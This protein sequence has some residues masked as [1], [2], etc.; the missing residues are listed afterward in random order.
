MIHL[1]QCEFF[2]FLNKLSFSMI[3]ISASLWFYLFGPWKVPVSAPV[4]TFITQLCTKYFPPPL[5]CLLV[6]HYERYWN[7]LWSSSHSIWSELLPCTGWTAGQLASSCQLL[8][9]LVVLPQISAGCIASD[10]PG[11]LR[12]IFRS[13]LSKEPRGLSVYNS[14]DFCSCLSGHFSC[15]SFFPGSIL[16]KC[17]QEQ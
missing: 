5:F 14:H 8:R 12:T 15:L 13:S 7:L 10:H 16:R 11:A 17:P 3:F 1:D 2:F 4:V 9:A 6:L